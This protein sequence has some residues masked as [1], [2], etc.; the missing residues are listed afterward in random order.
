MTTVKICLDWL[1]FTEMLRAFAFIYLLKYR[2]TFPEADLILRNTNLIKISSELFNPILMS[3]NI[4]KCGPREALIF[5][6]WKS[7]TLLVDSAT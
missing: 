5:I 4:K 7:K 2:Y 3:W 1:S 6:L